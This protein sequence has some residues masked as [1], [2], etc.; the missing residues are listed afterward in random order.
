MARQC[1]E[2]FCLSNLGEYP[3]KN[4]VRS[5][6]IKTVENFPNLRV[7]LDTFHCDGRRCKLVKVSGAIPVSFD[8]SSYNIPLCLYLDF[9]YPHEPPICLL[10]P[11]DTLSVRVCNYVDERGQINLP[12]QAEWNHS[13]SDIVGLLQLMQHEFAKECPLKYTGPLQHASEHVQDAAERDTVAQEGASKQSACNQGGS[14]QDSL[15]CMEGINDSDKQDPLGHMEETSDAGKQVASCSMQEIYDTGLQVPPKH[16]S[17]VFHTCVQDP[18]EHSEDACKQDPTSVPLEEICG[19]NLDKYYHREVVRSEIIAARQHFTDLRVTQGS[20]L[21]KEQSYN[22]VKLFGTIPV[23]YGGSTYNVPICVYLEHQHPYLPPIS[24]VEPTDSMTVCPGKYVDESGLIYLPYQKE[25]SHLGSDVVGLLQMMQHQF[26]KE[27]PVFS[28]KPRIFQEIQVDLNHQPRVSCDSPDGYGAKPEVSYESHS[29]KDSDPEGG[30]EIPEE[31]DIET[32]ISP[33]NPMTV[34]KVQ[35]V[36]LSSP[37]S[38]DRVSQTNLDR[39]YYPDLVRRDLSEAAQLYTT[40]NIGRGEFESDGQSCAMLKLE[41]TIPA[42]YKGSTYNIPV[43]FWLEHEHPY[44]PPV[45]IVQPTATMCIHGGKYVDAN[46]KV[47]M[48]YQREWCHPDSDLVGLIRKMQLH[49]GEE[50]PVFSPPSMSPG[51]VEEFCCNNLDQYLHCETVERD[52]IDTVQRF[53]ALRISLGDFESD[54][55]H[56]IMVKLDGIIPVWYNAATRHTPVCLWLDFQYPFKSPICFVKPSETMAVRPSR[57]V[58]SSGETKLPCQQ[59]WNFPGSDIVGLI[60]A[61]QQQFAKEYPLLSRPTPKRRPPKVKIPR[62]RVTQTLHC[63]AQGYSQSLSTSGTAQP[64]RRRCSTSSQIYSAESQQHRSASTSSQAYPMKPPTRRLASTS[65]QIASAKPS[66]H[67]STSTSSQ[68]KQLYS[69]K[70][71]TRRSSSMSSQT[72]PPKPAARHSASTS[73]QAYSR[74]QSVQRSSSTS[75]Q[76]HPTKQSTFLRCSSA[77]SGL[78]VP[79]SCYAADESLDDSCE[80]V[81]GKLKHLGVVGHLGRSLSNHAENGEH[82]DDEECEMETP[83]IDDSADVFYP[84]LPKPTESVRLSRNSSTMSGETRPKLDMPQYD[85]KQDVHDYLLLFEDVVRH[86]G[87]QES[88]WLL[89][90]RVANAGTKLERQ[91]RGRTSYGEARQEILLLHGKTAAEVWKELKSLAQQEETFHRYVLRAGRLCEEWLRL[92]TQS[93]ETHND[94]KSDATTLACLTKQVVLDSLKPGMRAFMRERK[95]SA[96]DIAEF[97]M[98]GALYQEAHGRRKSIVRS[99]SKV[100]R[101]MLRRA[102]GK[103]RQTVDNDNDTLR[104]SSSSLPHDLV[105]CYPRRG[106]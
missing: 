43:C 85:G 104:G 29:D 31:E 58:E 5:D 64:T 42:W 15:G 10:E 96:M 68:M 37:E 13:S 93:D 33:T 2:E 26:A 76:V 84:I 78:Q 66:T 46:G 71:S 61:M 98:T 80:I 59:E 40:L 49:F 39:Y 18:P 45:C 83:G 103:F 77:A 28:C 81:Q 95:C 48:P 9:K 36:Y 70:P 30:F 1:V 106:V 102:R 14:K 24:F 22:M 38:V 57:Y 74:K 34:T 75:S 92:S 41:G 101:P 100:W 20:F 65:S 54:G 7:C 32:R 72:C 79:G 3:N 87:Y 97:Q 73:S 35:R 86:N 89:L 16:K 99:I 60:R 17:E 11:P 4:T 69:R 27:C 105:D 56:R 25:W 88:E 67:R 62:S 47:E 55:V 50:C 90:L 52:L 8:D 51:E 44:Q 91:C 23:L 82:R 63:S 53:S 19:I 94:Q 6:L 21:S 12:Y